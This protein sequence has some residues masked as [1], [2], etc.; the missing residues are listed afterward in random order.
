MI[1]CR[2]FSRAILKPFIEQALLQ[3]SNFLE[4]VPAD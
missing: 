4:K 1:I 3:L 2:I